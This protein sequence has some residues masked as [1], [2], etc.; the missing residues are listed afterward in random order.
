MAMD[1]PT[2]IIA[3]MNQT[4]DVGKTTITANLGVI[5]AEMGYRVLML[6]LDPQADLS[7]QFGVPESQSGMDNLLND[8]SRESELLLPLNERLS[9]IAAGPELDLFEQQKPS[10]K[11]GIKLKQ[12]LTS[13]I[14]SDIDIIL[15]DCAAISGLLGTNAVL[16]ATDML[17]PVSAEHGALRGMIKMLPVLQRVSLLRAESLRLWLCLN[18]LPD[19]TDFAY[20]FS[21]LLIQYFPKRVLK[22]VIYDNE[23][24]NPADYQ[25]LANDLLMGRAD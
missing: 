12:L 22:T 17:I 20:Q 18:K 11:M 6:D 14:Q 15:I 7:R 13:T 19:G 2:R 16:A 23:S 1:G 8:T 21:S 3:V 9:L 4:H 10:A 24:A 25:S 5:L